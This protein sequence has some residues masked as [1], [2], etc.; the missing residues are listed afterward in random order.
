[1]IW[2][3]L[4]PPN[5]PNAKVPANVCKQNSNA[6]VEADHLIK[7]W[8]IVNVPNTP[9]G[10]EQVARQRNSVRLPSF[11]KNSNVVQN[12]QRRETLKAAVD[13]VT[14][15]RLFASSFHTESGQVS[16]Y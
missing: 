5:V 9:S 16:K 14:N 2:R 7:A 12:K 1:L 13:N 10:E 8:V 11:P 6:G 4:L 3:T 15:H